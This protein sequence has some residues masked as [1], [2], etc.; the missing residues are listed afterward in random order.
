[1]DTEQNPK[2]MEAVE[3]CQ[4]QKYIKHILSGFFGEETFDVCKEF[5]INTY[6][7]QAFCY[8]AN[9]IQ[10]HNPDLVRRLSI[11]VFQNSGSRMVLANHTLKQ[12]NIIDDHT[13]DGR[14]SGRFSSVLSFL[15]KCAT[16]MGR[17]LFQMQ[18][19]NP[20][21]DTQWL[22]SEYDATATLLEKGDGVLSD[23][24]RGLYK[25]KDLEKICRQLVAKRVYPS[26]VYFL[27]EG[28]RYIRQLNEVDLGL[29]S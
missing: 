12:L 1:M 8:L 3:N 18:M 7:T 6:A 27:Y 17:R 4:K 22:N 13:M 23:I 28:I 11:P 19:T 21:F 5:N 9:F 24:R 29:E 25:I 16:P 10:E 2:K 15:N 20:V 26:S 14:S